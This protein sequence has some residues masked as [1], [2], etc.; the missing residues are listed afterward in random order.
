VAELGSHDAR[1]IVEDAVRHFGTYHTESAAVQ[2]GER[3]V[4]RDRRLLYYYGN[5]LR[6]YGLPSLER[7]GEV[8]SEVRRG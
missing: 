8:H 4:H 6:N 2:D 1:G 7:R 3:V 5:R